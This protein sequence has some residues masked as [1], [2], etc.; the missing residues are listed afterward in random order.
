VFSLPFEAK[1]QQYVQSRVSEFW[2][3]IQDWLNLWETTQ[4]QLQVAQTSVYFIE[5]T[6]NASVQSVS[7]I[8]QHILEQLSDLIR[9]GADEEVGSFQQMITALEK[10]TAAAEQQ[11]GEKTILPYEDLEEFIHNTIEESSKTAIIKLLQC[12]TLRSHLLSLIEVQLAYRNVIVA[13]M[14]VQAKTAIKLASQ[15]RKDFSLD[16]HHD[17]ADERR[18]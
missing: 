13:D 9:N 11:S 10:V 1:N 2:K 3:Q 14:V 8:L 15:L 17:Q 12:S 16:L 5:P 7:P 4:G 6:P 18:T